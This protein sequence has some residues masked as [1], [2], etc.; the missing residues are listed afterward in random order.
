MQNPN[1][2]V[3][4]DNC[5]GEFVESIEPP[6]VVRTIFVIPFYISYFQREKKKS[7]IRAISCCFWYS[8]CRFNCWKFDKKSR[9]NY[10]PM[11]WL[12]CRKGKMG[13]SSSCSSV[14]TWPW[15][16][17]WLNSWSHY[18]S[19]FPR[20]IPF[21]SNGW[22]GCQGIGICTSLFHI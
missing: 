19:V 21:T 11:W 13:K 5:Y 14:C 1:C 4:V 16:W 18:E 20:F 7:W 17:L 8:G 2:L 12:C 15:S 9:W 22:R 10:S 3:M 6:M